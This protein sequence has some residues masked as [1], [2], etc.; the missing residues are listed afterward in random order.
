MYGYIYLTE[1]LING[2][3]YIGQHKYDKPEIDPNYFGSGIIITDAIKK[4][5]KENFRCSIIECCETKDDLTEKEIFYI[6]KFDAVS[7][8]NYYN[9][10]SGKGNSHNYN[11]SETTA[12]KLSVI[13]KN[14]RT[15][16][17]GEEQ[18][19][20]SIDELDNYL[21]DGWKLGRL[22]KDYS[23]RVEKFKSTHYDES[24]SDNIIKWKNN[25]SNWGKNK[26]WVNNSVDET[27]IPSELVDE[28][29]SNGYKLGRL[30]ARGKNQKV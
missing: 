1:N 9:V 12:Q 15:I 22:P 7:D 11:C 24:N 6:N 30:F 25:L 5:G 13:Q 26:R 23:C 10:D 19:V 2:K 17:N 28:Y 16:N 3:K 21:S 14:H 8:P 20:I 29:L 27:Q 4:Y 18:K